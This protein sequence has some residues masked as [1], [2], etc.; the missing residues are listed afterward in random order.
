MFEDINYLRD[1]D[2]N[3]YFLIDKKSDWRK[4][5]SIWETLIISICEDS[6]TNTKTNIMGKKEEEKNV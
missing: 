5:S 4:K 3:F 1:W 2:I 6:T